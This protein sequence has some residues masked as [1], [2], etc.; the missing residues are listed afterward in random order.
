MQAETITKPAVLILLGPPGAGKGTQAR[1]LEE[2]F[3]LV[4]LSTGDLLRAAV[5]AG[6]E[7]GKAAKA[8]MEAGGL[9]SDDI[10]IAI[11]RDR[12]AEPDCARGVILDGFPRT[13]VQAEALDKLLSENCQKVN[14]AIS[15]DVEDAEMVARI[16]GRYTCANCG[17]GYH[18][19]FKQPKVEGVCDRCG[20]T[21]FSRRAD[22]NAETVASRLAAY[23]EQTAPLIDYYQRQGVLKR[24][25]AMGQIDEIAR[26]L[27]GIVGEAMR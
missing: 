10:V 16:A 24:L 14:A 7:A 18:D 25:N 12:L 26:G 2:K 11:L 8:V 19:Q 27:E 13:T 23:H 1:M 9:V 15:L 5:A 22:D 20:G 17:E 6:T 4:Q 21:A 3:G